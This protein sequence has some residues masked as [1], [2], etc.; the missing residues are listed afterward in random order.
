MSAPRTPEQHRTSEHRISE[1]RSDSVVVRSDQTHLSQ[2]HH[3]E[4]GTP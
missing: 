3:K 4:G 1:H 2:L